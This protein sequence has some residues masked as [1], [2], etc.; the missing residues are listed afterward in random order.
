MSIKNYTKAE[1]AAMTR[2]QLNDYF[3]E[4]FFMLDPINQ[5]AYIMTMEALVAG[6]SWETA[7]EKAAAFLSMQPGYEKEVR[8][9]LQNCKEGISCSVI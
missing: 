6:E 5:R 9:W 4:L 8:R 1:L 3:V 7:S 2:E